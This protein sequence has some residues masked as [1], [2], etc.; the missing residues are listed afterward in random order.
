MKTQHHELHIRTRETV[1]RKL[2][3]AHKEL[4]GFQSLI[5]LGQ[6]AKGSKAHI[7]RSKDEWSSA[8]YAMRKNAIDSAISELQKWQPTADISWL[9]ILKMAD[10]TIGQKMEELSVAPKTP[11]S[12][13]VKLRSLLQD[14][15]P[16]ETVFLRPDGLK[17]G[18]LISTLPF[19]V[20]RILTRGADT[21]IMD[22]AVCTPPSTSVQPTITKDVVYLAQKLRGYESSNFG[23]FRCK[24]VVKEDS[25][26]QRGGGASF[27]LVFKVPRGLYNPQSLRLTLLGSE[28]PS[29][30]SH[31]VRL[32]LE[33]AKSVCH[34]HILD[35]VHKNIRPETILLC[36]AS[37]TGLLSPF[38]VGFERFRKDGG[39]TT[40]MGSSDWKQNMYAHP[41]RYGLSPVDAYVMQHDIYSLGVCLLE[42][43]LWESFI[44]YKE[45][46]DQPTLSH[47]LTPP[48]QEASDQLSTAF[49][50]QFLALARKSLPARMGTRYAG[51]VE[52]CL[53]CLDGGNEDFGDES[54]FQDENGILVG[55]RYIEKVTSLFS[56][57]RTLANTTRSLRNLTPSRSGY[58]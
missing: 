33:L 21:L 15:R 7:S 16:Q 12:Y 36:Q 13:A 45:Q 2:E 39:H 10:K 46:A 9:L 40:L 51:V 43:G 49:K 58:N 53:T 20:A 31:V 42:I 57:S 41:K 27:V 50:E 37:S 32:G 25:P 48:T 38:L 47:I 18:A 55:V 44:S 3:D 28:R 22:T 26:G 11:Q 35:F 5:E 29:S 52:T 54:E 23:L 4:V 17:D 8:K 30:L 34:V 56:P 24:G 19:C 1:Q 14:S 6:N